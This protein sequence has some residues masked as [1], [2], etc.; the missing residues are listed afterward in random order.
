MPPAKVRKI[1]PTTLRLVLLATSERGWDRIDHGDEDQLVFARGWQTLRL[2]RTQL[3][4][5]TF[6]LANFNKE[7]DL[8]DKN[9]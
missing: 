5:S 2:T 9:R 7:L 1:P 3:C 4:S 6:T 8:Y